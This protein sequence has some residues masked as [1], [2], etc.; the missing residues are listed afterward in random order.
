MERREMHTA[1]LGRG[2]T[3][4]SSPLGRFGVDGRILKWTLK[5]KM[6]GCILD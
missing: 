3:E 5:E 1:Y 2:K 6:W 4:G